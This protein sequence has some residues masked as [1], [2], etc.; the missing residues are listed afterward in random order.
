MKWISVKDRLPKEDGWYLVYTRYIIVPPR[1]VQYK[2]D[3]EYP[4]IGFYQNDITHWM[5]LPEPPKEDE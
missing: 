4:F 2:K 1:V 5:P 3:A